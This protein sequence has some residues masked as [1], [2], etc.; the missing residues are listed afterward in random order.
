MD[1]N[2]N[3]L[4]FTTGNDMENL[5]LE[6]AKRQRYVSELQIK[7]AE[8]E[9]SLKEW[10]MHCQQLMSGPN[11][12]NTNGNKVLSNANEHGASEVFSRWTSK[13]KAT[14]D[15]ILSLGHHESTPNKKENHP[16]T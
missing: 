11:N 14:T 12:T 7:L 9:K 1:N 6:L 13:I 3:K 5:L 16:R 8:A 2:S 10:E 4:N 15:E